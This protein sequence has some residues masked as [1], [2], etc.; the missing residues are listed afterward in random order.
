MK[1]VATTVN[2]RKR[3]AEGVNKLAQWQATVEDW[4]G[5]DLLKDSSILIHSGSLTKISAG[6]I[7]RG[8]VLM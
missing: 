5:D 1:G 7:D 6:I 2:E 3:R 8:F 4:R